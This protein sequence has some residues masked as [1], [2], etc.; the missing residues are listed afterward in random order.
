LGQRNISGWPGAR[1][2]SWQRNVAK[3]DLTELTSEL[4]GAGF[5]GL[6]IDLDGYTANAPAFRAD[7]D[8]VLGPP[9]LTG[10]SGRWR[11][12]RIPRPERST[13]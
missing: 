12:Y 7:L 9:D 1:C 10:K 5:A 2:D 4:R 8:R 13:D 11:F 6:H 3:G